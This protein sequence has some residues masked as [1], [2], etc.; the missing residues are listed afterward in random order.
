MGFGVTGMIGP[1]ANAMA[2]AD[3]KQDHCHG[4]NFVRELP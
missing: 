2:A 1:M 4:R 3:G